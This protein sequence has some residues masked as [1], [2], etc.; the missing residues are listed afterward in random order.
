[1]DNQLQGAILLFHDYALINDGLRAMLMRTRLAPELKQQKAYPL[2]NIPAQ[3][4]LFCG[5]DSLHQFTYQ[6]EIH[7]L[8]S[9]KQVKIIM[10]IDACAQV[11]LNTMV[12][13]GVK[14]IVSTDVIEEKLLEII[15]IIRSG[16][17]Y[18]ASKLSL[19]KQGKLLDKEKPNA[20]FNKLTERELEVLK[21]ITDE[22]TIKE[23]AKALFISPRTVETHRRNLI[24]KL[25]V[26]SSVGLVKAYLK[27]G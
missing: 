2:D 8:L 21:C 17:A 18:I 4:I 7:P 15:R 16:G 5:T 11:D 20:Y 24:Q 22:M 13:M 9:E 10:L 6:G 14:G 27:T 25:K 23:I 19:G 3:A 26:K 12:N 1:M